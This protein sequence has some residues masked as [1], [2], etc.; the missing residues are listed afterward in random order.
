M[1][2]STSNP[3]ALMF[4]NEAQARRVWSYVSTDAKA[5]VL[6][7]SYITDAVA[8]RMRSGD[9]VMVTDTTNSLGYIGYVTVGATAGTLA[10]LPAFT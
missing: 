4:S 1:A 3:P 8:L 7:A 5:A 6:A 2:Y 9:I 10:A